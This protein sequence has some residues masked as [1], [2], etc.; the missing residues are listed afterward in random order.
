MTLFLRR[1]VARS[2]NHHGIFLRLIGDDVFAKML[3]V[4]G[5]RRGGLRVN[6]LEFPAM[7]LF[8]VPGA[9]FGH[10]ADLCFDA[11]Q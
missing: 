5:S 1:G 7:T 10:M 11:P 2:F 3:E 6:P 4:E 8:V 9:K